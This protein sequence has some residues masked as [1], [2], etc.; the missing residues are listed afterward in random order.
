MY[1][2]AAGLDGP[3]DL[4]ETVKPFLT[5][6]VSQAF[7]NS[8]KIEAQPIT[9][10]AKPPLL[11]MTL[12][13]YM[14]YGLGS[15]DY[16]G[17]MEAGFWTMRCNS[18]IPSVDCEVEGTKYEN[19][20]FA[21][22]SSKDS[23]NV[24]KSIA[25]GAFGKHYDIRKEPKYLGSEKAEYDGGFTNSIYALASQELIDSRDFEESLHSASAI[26]REPSRRAFLFS[27]KRD[28]VV[29]VTNT[30]KFQQRHGGKVQTY[31]YENREHLVCDKPGGSPF[32]VDHGGAQ[33]LANIFALAFL[34]TL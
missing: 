10:Y 4:L 23:L 12:V 3:Y 17:K 9:N 2:G 22:K 32:P 7:N 8:Y 26:N 21:M 30:E 29:S 11:A 20:Y 27:L 15:A 14:Y 25:F 1:K 33:V 16:S 5:H 24:A 13:S 34:N 28:S 19:I 31:F 6:K 18:P